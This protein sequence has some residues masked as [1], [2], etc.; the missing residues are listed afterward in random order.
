MG[1]IC[2]IDIELFIDN[3]V[4]RNTV[5]YV[6]RT[7]ISWFGSIYSNLLLK[8][9][10]ILTYQLWLRLHCLITWFDLVHPSHLYRSIG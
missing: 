8:S 6:A 5:I 2:T 3:E 10:P 4:F 9:L 1:Q 7:L